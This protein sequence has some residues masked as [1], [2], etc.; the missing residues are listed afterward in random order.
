MG[1][2]LYLP[3]ILSRK[4]VSQLSS[5]PITLK[6]IMKFGRPNG[7]LYQSGQDKKRAAQVTGAAN[8]KGLVL[9]CP[10]RPLQG[11]LLTEIPPDTARQ[12]SPS[13]LT[14]TVPEPQGKRE[15][16]RVSPRRGKALAW[17]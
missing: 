7:D 17:E 4:T 11:D 15:L 5:T 13:L 12:E 16:W 1:T 14:L 3:D 2:H 6:K 10:S 8:K 9:V